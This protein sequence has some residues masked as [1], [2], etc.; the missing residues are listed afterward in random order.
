M[1]R[2]GFGFVVLGVW[3]LQACASD[4][5][6]TSPPSSQPTPSPQKPIFNWTPQATNTTINFHDVFF[7]GNNAGWVVGEE[8][9]LLSTVNG[10]VAWPAVPVNPLKE[11]FQA[12]FL[13]ND[14]KGWIASRLSDN[15]TG[16]NVLI[17][18]NGGAY[19]EPQL[20]VDSPLNTVFFVDE[21]TGWAAGTRGQIFHTTNG[22]T[23]WN[24]GNI[25]AEIEIYDLS[26]LNKNTGWAAADSGGIYRTLDGITWQAEI[27][28][29]TASLHAIHFVDTLHGW[30]CGGQRP[31]YFLQ[32]CE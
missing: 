8:A 5:G 26:F 9:I 4:E 20:T 27:L 22:G 32:R 21:L 25:G 28:T 18:I 7:M 30:A 13:V 2:G 17:S 31:F 16:G 6:S 1:M 15:K 23:Q 24:T 29:L 3:L 10:G 19:P 11:D 12:V 14:Q